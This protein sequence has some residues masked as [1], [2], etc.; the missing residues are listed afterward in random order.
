[1]R[2]LIKLS[3]SS[4]TNFEKIEPLSDSVKEQKVAAFTDSTPRCFGIY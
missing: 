1:M 3:P 4:E 2:S